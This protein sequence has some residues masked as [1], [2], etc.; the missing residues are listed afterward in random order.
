MQVITHILNNV[1]SRNAGCVIGDCAK[2]DD[3]CIFPSTVTVQLQYGEIKL[4]NLSN[5]LDR[6]GY[7]VVWKVRYG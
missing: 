3:N 7:K 5:A 6:Q 1:W 4:H 2:L